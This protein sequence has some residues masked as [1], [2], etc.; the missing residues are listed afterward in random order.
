MAQLN[1]KWWPA[2]ACPRRVVDV[3]SLFVITVY[4]WCPGW[5]FVADKKMSC[6]ISLI[7]F[8]APHCWLHSSSSSDDP[9]QPRLAWWWNVS[10]YLY[11][12]CPLTSPTTLGVAWCGIP[13]LKVGVIPTML[14]IENK[15]NKE[16]DLQWWI[17][18]LLRKYQK[19]IWYSMFFCELDDWGYYLFI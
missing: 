7:D 1:D 17:C 16:K 4:K 10:N 11:L 2:P 9:C 18:C 6:R 8:A 3:R 14:Q 13:S 15:M 12:Q 5:Q 19:R